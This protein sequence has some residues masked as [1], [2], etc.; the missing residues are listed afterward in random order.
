MNVRMKVEST[1]SSDSLCTNFNLFLLQTSISAWNQCGTILA[2]RT[3]AMCHYSLLSGPS[4]LYQTNY[5]LDNLL[6]LGVY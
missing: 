4:R 2:T 6:D 5:F 3:G 1:R